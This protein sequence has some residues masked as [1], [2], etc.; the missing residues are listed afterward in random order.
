MIFGSDRDGGAAFTAYI[1]TSMDLARDEAPLAHILQ[2]P[3]DWS[4][5][6]KWISY[7][8]PQLPIESIAGE[9]KPFQF[10]A[11]QFMTTGGRFSPDRKW[12]AYASNETGRFE[13]YV[14][15]LTE[16]PAGAERKIQMSNQGGELVHA[17][18]PIGLTMRGTP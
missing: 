17:T 6:R 13:I 14:R 8:F 2:E 1:K 11:T 15:P 9:G 4:R 5:D 16:G 7:G 18:E 12:I 10:I 3:H